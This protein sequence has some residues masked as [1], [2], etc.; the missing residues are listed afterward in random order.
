M[1]NFLTILWVFGMVMFMVAFDKTIRLRNITMVFAALILSIAWP[2]TVL[3]GMAMHLD[4]MSIKSGD[5][6]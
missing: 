6:Q 3:L 4:G 2:L 1:S 5:K